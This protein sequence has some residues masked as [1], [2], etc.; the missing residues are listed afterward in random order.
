MLSAAAVFVATALTGGAALAQPVMP[1]PPQNLP[2][3]S[4]PD[5]GPTG[6]GMLV[7]GSSVRGSASQG[8]P[9]QSFLA[10]DMAVVVTENGVHEWVL[11]LPPGHTVT[12]E[13]Q[14]WHLADADGALLGV[15]TKPRL[16]GDGIQGV[17]VEQQLSGHIVQARVAGF[18]KG[19]KAVLVMAAQRSGEQLVQGEF[20]DGGQ[21]GFV[22]IPADY[23]YNLWYQ[24]QKYRVQHDYCS[25]APNGI[26]FV[27]YYVNFR[28]PC[29]IHDMCYQEFNDLPHS[30]KVGE[31]MALCQRPFLENMIANCHHQIG[32]VFS[33]ANLLQCRCVA[34]TYHAAVSLLIETQP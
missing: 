15:V 14:A 3:Q 1:W 16:I 33:E 7:E 2:G 19:A 26:W 24:P 30:E 18:P 25:Y 17:V 10:S 22:G 5:Q 34:H 4:A 21:M 6:H 13:G 31:R 9:S 8:L 23:E 11:D 28:G 12:D 27:P 32:G 29:A 20:G